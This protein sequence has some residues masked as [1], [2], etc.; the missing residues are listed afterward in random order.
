VTVKVRQFGQN[1]NG[2][3]VAYTRLHTQHR[4]KISLLFHLIPMAEKGEIVLNF[5]FS[6]GS[7]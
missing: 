6:S 2:G 5:R 7:V 3:H 4:V 1:L